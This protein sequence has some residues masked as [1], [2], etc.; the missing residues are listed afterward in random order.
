M[1]DLSVTTETERSQMHKYLLLCIILIFIISTESSAHD[2]TV[3]I[4]KSYPS[5]IVRA[6]YF[7]AEPLSYA[8]VMIFSPESDVV[9]YQ[10]GR[11]DKSGFFAFVPNSRGDWKITV[12]DEMGH[13]KE[14]VVS[15]ADDFF[16]GEEATAIIAHTNHRSSIHDLQPLYKIIFGLALILGITGIFYWFKARQVLER[17]PDKH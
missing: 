5:V 6:S 7:Q 17:K 16:T 4:T 3:E 13:F 9:E 8:E 14:T 11:T 10:Y 1:T 12:D 15:I 2:V